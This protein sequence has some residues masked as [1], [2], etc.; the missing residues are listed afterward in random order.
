MLFCDGLLGILRLIPGSDAEYLKSLLLIF[1][2]GSDEVR[3]LT[4]TGTAP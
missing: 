2:I 4:T 3:N 1:I